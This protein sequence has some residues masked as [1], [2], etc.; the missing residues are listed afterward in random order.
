[1]TESRGRATIDSPGGTIGT[2]RITQLPRA[3]AKQVRCS[4][5]VGGRR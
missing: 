3:V 1:M 4:D 2:A 5:Q